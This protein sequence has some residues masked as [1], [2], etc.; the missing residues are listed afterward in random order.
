MSLVLHKSIAD[1]IFESINNIFMMI[2]M[3][4]ILLPFAFLLLQS[5]TG[6]ADASYLGFKL[7]S[8]DITFNNYRIV[9]MNQY[10]WTGYFNTIY[11]TVFGTFASL[12]FTSVGAYCLSKKC[13]PNRVLWTFFIVFTMFFGGGLIPTYLVINGLKLIDNRL[14]FILPGLVG[15]F[16]LIIMRNYFQQLPEEI[17]ESGR[18]D[19]ASTL[20]TF[21]SLI[22]PMSKPILATV[23]LW[24][25][26]GHWN[27]W[28]DQLI[29]I[30]DVKKFVLQVILRRIVL[31]GTQQ[32]M[33]TAVAQQDY[34]AYPDGIKAASIFFTTLPILCVYPF[35]QKY[36]VKG[37][38]MGSLKG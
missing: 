21:F 10:I 38:I 15:S 1:K 23:A 26:V 6:S 16:N 36:F 37:I 20:R 8:G 9:I 34:E 27:A 17:E 31:D 19:G 18:V 29:Y 25:A 32:L 3:V 24:L 33:D 30:R 12:L 14:V 35:A 7:L 2:F 22:L 5:I 11:R 28:F 13:F 4:T